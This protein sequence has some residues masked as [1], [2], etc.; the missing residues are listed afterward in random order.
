MLPAYHLIL[1]NESVIQRVVLK[2]SWH[3][4]ARHERRLSGCLFSTSTVASWLT[5]DRPAFYTPATGLLLKPVAQVLIRDAQYKLLRQGLILLPQ[6]QS[7]I[8]RFAR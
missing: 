5:A 7:L 4:A 8:V 3:I 1:S 2:F 6:K